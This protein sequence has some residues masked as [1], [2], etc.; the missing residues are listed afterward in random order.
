[1]LYYILEQREMG[2]AYIMLLHFIYQLMEVSHRC[3]VYRQL[4]NYICIKDFMQNTPCLKKHIREVHF[5]TLIVL[6]LQEYR[7]NLTKPEYVMKTAIDI[8]NPGICSPFVAVL[9]LASVLCSPVKLLC[10]DIVNKR[11][12]DLYHVT[13]L[14]E[15]MWM[16]IIKCIYSGLQLMTVLINWIILFL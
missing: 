12:M 10:K 3:Y 16:R 15:R 4:L 6:S 7:I 8:K 9:S 2:I 13:L 11:L 14:Q 5:L 1:M